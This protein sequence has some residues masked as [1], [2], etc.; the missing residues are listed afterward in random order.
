MWDSLGLVLYFIEI[1][2]IGDY[3]NIFCSSGERE[4]GAEIWK[5]KGNVVGCEEWI[6]EEDSK[7]ED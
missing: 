7:E 4:N 5:V 6:S 3:Q 2:L 1:V